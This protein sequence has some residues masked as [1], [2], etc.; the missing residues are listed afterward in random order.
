MRLGIFFAMEDREHTTVSTLDQINFMHFEVSLLDE[1]ITRFVEPGG[2]KR[3]GGF[4]SIGAELLVALDA[5]FDV[6]FTPDR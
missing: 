1:R 3:G 6:H 5:E 4:V 2:G